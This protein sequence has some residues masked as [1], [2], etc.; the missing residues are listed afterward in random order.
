VIA[1][2]SYGQVPD[3]P[4]SGGG[5]PAGQSAPA[6]QPAQGSSSGNG[7]GGGGGQKNGSFL[8]KDVPTFDPGNE[9][10]TWDGKNW[11][12]NNNRIFE[13]RFEK[14]LN[15]PEETK[16]V[17]QQYQLVIAKILNLLAPSN[18]TVQN[19]DAAFG[20]L[21]RGSNFEIDAH[22]CD[23][24]ADAVYSAWKALNAQNRLLAANE[25]LDRERTQEYWNSQ[26]ASMGDTVRDAGSSGN[27]K[28]KGGTGGNPNTQSTLEIYED[29]MRATEHTKRIV[30]I[31]AQI[32]ANQVKRELNS[33]QA[34]VEFQALI[35]QLFMQRRFQHV[36]MATR[37]YRAVFT[38]GDTKL[39]VGK[40]TKDLFEKSSGM[41]PTVGTL[42]SMANEAI[43]DVREGVQAYLYLLDKQELESASK[44]LAEAFI[45][46]EYVPEIRTLPR[47]KKRQA[48]EFTH[49]SYQLIS[50]LDVKDYT[51]AQTLVEDLTKTAKDFDSSKPLGLIETSKQIAAMHIA[52]AR[53]AALKGD[54]Q[55]LETELTAATEIWP[56]NP[57]L[58]EISTQIFKTGDVQQKAVID[59]EELLSQKNYRQIY[60]DRARFIGALGF[61]PDKAAKLKEVL[62]NMET[63]E[64]AIMRADEMVRQNNYPGAWESVEKIAQ[65][66]PDDTKL[67]KTRA[68]LTPHAADFVR[69]LQDA[70][71]MEKR[72][73]IG[74][75]LALYLKAKKIYPASDFAGEGVDRLVKKIIPDNT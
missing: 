11:N 66:F 65:Q 73:Q 8:G 56:R 38:D 13:A 59:F 10:M 60:E 12:V 57:A 48:L 15:A 32:K 51:L 23:S 14:Y 42:D 28:G 27:G 3:A 68:D 20:L 26:H 31:E 61:Y 5:A 46:G 33:I 22:L 45:E 36:L 4:H 16:A 50:A 71:D 9:I 30:E 67:S 52:K 1:S 49:K 44:R 69:T 54:N 7:S 25:S 17:D 74:A 62:Q 41:P 64:V 58:V 18:A 2:L 55:T 70:Q 35:L 34:K 47:E 6:S 40:D 37:F 43:R 72:D 19:V 75:S 39:N 21:P 29:T 24:I 63:I 53:N